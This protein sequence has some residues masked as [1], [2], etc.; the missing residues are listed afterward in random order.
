MQP[1]ALLDAANHVRC[2][3]AIHQFIHGA[4][5]TLVA[6]DVGDCRHLADV[7]VHAYEERLAWLHSVEA[8]VQLAV[9]RVIDRSGSQVDE[10][11]VQVRTD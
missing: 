1:V 2:V 5:Q 9:V 10:L 11:A 6:F 8:L 7:E 3:V 4:R